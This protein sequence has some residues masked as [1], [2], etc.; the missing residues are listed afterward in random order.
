MQVAKW[1]PGIYLNAK[2]YFQIPYES[3]NGRLS[4]FKFSYMYKLKAMLDRIRKYKRALIPYGM[5]EI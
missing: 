3:Y 4:F 1:W 2:W 5:A